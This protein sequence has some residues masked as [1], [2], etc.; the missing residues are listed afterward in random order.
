MNT[1]RIR[2]LQRRHR[3]PSREFRRLLRTVL[4]R[5]GCHAAA[6]TV[7]YCTENR[8]RQLNRDFRKI[9]AVTDVLSFTGGEPDEEGGIDLGEIIICPAVAQRNA[10]EYGVTWL[11]ELAALHVHGALHLLGRDHETDGGEMMTL[12]AGLLESIPWRAWFPPAG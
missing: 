7:V 12:Q 4:E 8:I 3:M 5:M 6:L 10:G 11:E 2:N 9:D 1:I